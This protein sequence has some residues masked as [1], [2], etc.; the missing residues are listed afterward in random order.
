VR[1]EA[2]DLFEPPHALPAPGDWLSWP[3]RVVALEP[4]DVADRRPLRRDPEGRWEAI[5]CVSG[6]GAGEDAAWSVDLGGEYRHG[7]FQ[8]TRMELE[9][10]AD[11]DQLD[12]PDSG[13]R[14]LY[15]L[16]LRDVELTNERAMTSFD[17]HL[18]D[19]LQSLPFSEWVDKYAEP[20]SLV[21]APTRRQEALRLDHEHLRLSIRDRG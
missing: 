2:L 20:E 11:G 9:S 4:L 17:E 14:R 13:E 8:M 6:F 3:L 12:L 18:S 16:Q 10:L 19:H 21:L 15:Q 7:P 1:S 5:V